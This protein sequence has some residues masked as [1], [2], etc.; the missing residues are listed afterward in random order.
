MGDDEDRD[1]RSFAKLVKGVVPLAPAD[2]DKTPPP[3]SARPAPAPR[4]SRDEAPP[5]QGF[6]HPDP[7]EPLL[8]FAPGFDR[9]S[10]RRLRTG[11]TRPERRVDPHGQTRDGARARVLAAVAE[12][13]AAG[14]RCLLVI[15][16]RSQGRESGPVLRAAL[17]G[18][19]AEPAVAP[20][21]LAFAP[22]VPR[23]GGAGATYVLLRRAR[24]SRDDR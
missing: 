7:D 9:R 2:P 23:D 11:Q 4:A 3:P 17:P 5:A 24:R 19:L 20:R 8:G 12:A 1:D 13:A 14:E 10:L 18:W 22:A 15:H 6:E 21:V 16:G